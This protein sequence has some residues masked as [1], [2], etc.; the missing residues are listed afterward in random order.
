MGGGGGGET[1]E[2][3]VVDDSSGGVRM[4][5][6]LLSLEVREDERNGENEKDGERERGEKV[7]CKVRE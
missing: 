7:S 5:E 6:C 3:V 1:A 2:K 4:M